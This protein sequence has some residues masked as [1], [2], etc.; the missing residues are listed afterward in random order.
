MSTEN[1]EP[2]TPDPTGVETPA[3]PPK[4]RGY[5]FIVMSIIGIGAL[6]VISS[7]FTA[8]TYSL[9]VTALVEGAERY[10]DRDVKIVGTVTPTS[11]PDITTVPSRSSL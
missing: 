6:L 8:G 7:S 1:H 9:T 2:Q 5:P 10:M 4:K 3:A 11:G